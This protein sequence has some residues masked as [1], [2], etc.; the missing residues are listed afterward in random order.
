VRRYLLMM[1]SALAIPMSA[2]ACGMASNANTAATGAATTVATA[3]SATPTPTPIGAE[4]YYGGCPVDA[5]VKVA[6]DRSA[7]PTDDPDYAAIQA[8]ACFATVATAQ[9]AGY[10]PIPSPTPQV[11]IVY[12]TSTPQP[13]EQT[14][15]VTG[16]ITAPDCFGGFAIS[17][18]NVTITNE[19]NEIV[20]AT[21][22]S[23]CHNVSTTRTGTSFTLNVKRAEFYQIKIGTH[24]GPTYT[25]DQMQQMGWHL[26]LTLN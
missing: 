5:P 2:L 3:H 24:G 20:G 22:T 14:F 17:N 7:H 6:A 21:A 12:V 23:E 1:M 9:Q 4:P 15:L 11:V 25:F 13:A 19:R 10:A 26:T 16:T 8:I 18:A